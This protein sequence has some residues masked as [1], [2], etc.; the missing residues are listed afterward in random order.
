MALVIYVALFLRT[1]ARLVRAM[2]MTADRVVRSE[3]AGILVGLVGIGLVIQGEPMAY[4]QFV[5]IYLALGEAAARTV[6]DHR[7]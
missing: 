7:A 3:L 6:L 4:S 1:G 2:R 5:W